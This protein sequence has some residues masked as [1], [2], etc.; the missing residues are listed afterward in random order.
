MPKIRVGGVKSYRSKGRI[1]HYHRATGIRIEFDISV[2]PEKFLARVRELDRA[3]LPIPLAPP[4]A[5]DIAGNDPVD[6]KTL[7]SL[8]DAW[9]QS[10]EWKAL[11][12]QTQ[13]TY[14]RIIDR[15]TGALKDA[16]ALPVHVLTPSK[17]VQ[18]RDSVTKAKKR[19]L[20]NYAVKVLRVA[21][22]WGRLHGWSELNPAAGV[23]LL[24]RAADAPEPNRAWS[25]DEFQIVWKHAS[26]RLRRALALACYAG[27]RLGDILVVPWAAWDGQVLTVRQSKTGLLVQITAPLPLREE[28]NN[29]Q[30][31][32][33]QIVVNRAGQP[34]TRDGLQTN[35][36]RLIK[37]LEQKSLVKPGLCFHGLRHSLGAALYDLG[38]DREARKA[39]LGH[40]SDAASIV[41]E[42][43]GNRRAASDRAFAAYD[44]YLASLSTAKNAK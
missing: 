42:R 13:I 17:I 15:R 29:A 37:K 23:P 19:W 25:V 9:Q 26:P 20:G 40:K 28:L 35:L 14:L 22:A 36:W 38:L 5:P 16:L 6:A 4:P 39:A 3:A 33:T 1:Y 27:L 21:F 31:E 11:R 32:G 24:Q 34:Y 30:R 7:S 44:Q 12:P 18:L 8:F 41:Y 2:E 10:Q 43:A